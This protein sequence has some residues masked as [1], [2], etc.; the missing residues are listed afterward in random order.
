[1][2]DLPLRRRANIVCRDLR[3]FAQDRVSRLTVGT[4]QRE[5]KYTQPLDFSRRA[6]DVTADDSLC[7]RAPIGQH[8]SPFLFNPD[9][10][11]QLPAGAARIVKYY[12]CILELIQAYLSHHRL[13]CS[14]ALHT[15]Q[16]FSHLRSIN[17]IAQVIQ[18]ENKISSRRSLLNLH[19]WVACSSSNHCSVVDSKH[20]P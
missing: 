11:S 18:S 9:K 2:F 3:I 6:L 20:D 8:E 16:R 10:Q 14:H 17:P 13:R 1:M 5:P 12:D 4:P 19:I 15:K 7:S